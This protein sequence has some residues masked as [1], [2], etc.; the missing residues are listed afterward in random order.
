M[1]KSASESSHIKAAPEQE[2]QEDNGMNIAEEPFETPRKKSKK[3]SKRKSLSE[4]THV[5]HDNEVFEEAQEKAIP[6]QKICKVLLTPSSR[7]M[8]QKYCRL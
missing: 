1:V 7:A 5:N 2:E 4:E 3:K 8:Q 6:E